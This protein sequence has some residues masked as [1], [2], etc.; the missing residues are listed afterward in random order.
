LA[1]KLA[2]LQAIQD[3]DHLRERAIIQDLVSVI[4]RSPR[5]LLPFEEVRE[6]LHVR[7]VGERGLRDIPLG[8]IVGSVGRYNDFTRTFLPR[9]W[10]SQ[11]RWVKLKTMAGDLTGWP[12]IEVYQVGSAYFVKDGNHRVSVAMEM[13]MKTI[14]AYVTECVAPVPLDNTLTAVDLIL[15]ADRADFLVRTELDRL[16]PDH[17]VEL[18]LPGRYQDLLAHIAAHQYSLEQGSGNPVPWEEATVSWYDTAYLPLVQL[19]EAKNLL[20]DFPHRTSADLYAWV[21]E[22]ELELRQACDTSQVDGGVA[23]D[24][25]ATLYSGRPLVAQIK[26]IRRR[27]DRLL[28]HRQPPCESQ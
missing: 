25:F 13:G 7:E 23:L 21:I 9:N 3:F 10:A 15:K 12:P 16:R 27:L 24:D 20:K 17:G 5:G 18:T 26:A 1:T 2:Q 22:H 14:E 28:K 11:Q 6:K 19:I 4:T 8:S